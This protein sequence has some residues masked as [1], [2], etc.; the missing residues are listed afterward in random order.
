MREGIPGGP[1]FLTIDDLY[2]ELLGKMKAAGLSQPQM[3]RI[4]TAACC[5]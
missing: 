1:E 2:K 5:R 4:G 3:R